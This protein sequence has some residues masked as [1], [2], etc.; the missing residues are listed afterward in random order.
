MGQ[1]RQSPDSWTL[2]WLAV[3]LALL[4][5]ILTACASIPHHVCPD[6]LPLKI[7]QDPTCHRGIC[8]YTCA[9]D[10]WAK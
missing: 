3:V 5:V 6:G 10:R 8:G 2:V 4:T 9:P 7:L 1:T